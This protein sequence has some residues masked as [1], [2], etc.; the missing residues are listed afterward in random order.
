MDVKDINF[1]IDSASFEE[2]KLNCPAHK[3]NYCDDNV[4]IIAGLFLITNENPKKILDS[5]IDKENVTDNTILFFERRHLYEL[6]GMLYGL[7]AALNLNK[8][9]LSNTVSAILNI[10]DRPVTYKDLKE[11]IDNYM[12]NFL[13]ID[14]SMY[15]NLLQYILHN[16]WFLPY[17][18]IDTLVRLGIDEFNNSTDE[19]EYNG[20]STKSDGDSDREG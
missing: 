4:D 3:L 13:S 1:D 5:Y 8:G 16:I 20:E 14:E 15:A 19:G 7:L 17:D 18:K 2:F 9:D 10:A 12:I 11:Y 6:G